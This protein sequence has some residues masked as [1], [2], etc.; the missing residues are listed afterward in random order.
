MVVVV[1]ASW[2]IAVVAVTHYHGH[3][4]RSMIHLDYVIASSD[5][6]PAAAV[7]GVALFLLLTLMQG[8]IHRRCSAASRVSV[9]GWAWRCV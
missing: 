8:R 9:V 6:S 3:D 1:A 2:M 4:R 7:D 5:T